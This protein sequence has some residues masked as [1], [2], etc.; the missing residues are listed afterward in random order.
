MTPYSYSELHW[1]TSINLHNCISLYKWLTLICQMSLSSSLVLLRPQACSSAVWYEHLSS[2]ISNILASALINPFAFSK[3]LFWPLRNVIHLWRAAAP[4]CD[5]FWTEQTE[6]LA[7]PFKRLR[8][9]TGK[10]FC[11]NYW[12]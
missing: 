12:F 1:A 10:I 8:C 2:M 4:K 5:I 11:F 3:K 7:T 9:I 6:Q